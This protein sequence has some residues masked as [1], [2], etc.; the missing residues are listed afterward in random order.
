MSIKSGTSQKAITVTAAAGSVRSA[1]LAVEL[2]E[3]ESESKSERITARD[4]AYS[5][6]K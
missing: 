6:L 2:A 3:V 4:K 5:R 1:K